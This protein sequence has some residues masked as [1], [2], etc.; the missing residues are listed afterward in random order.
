M[1]VG[2]GLWWFNRKI[3]PTQ[4]WVELSWVV[5]IYILRLNFVS[6]PIFLLL[7]QAACVRHPCWRTEAKLAIVFATTQLNSTQSWVG[8]IFL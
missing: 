5:A 8:L 2:F 6:A 4:L 3:R 7:V 1:G